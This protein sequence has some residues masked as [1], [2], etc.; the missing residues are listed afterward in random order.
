MHRPSPADIGTGALRCDR[1]NALDGAHE[2]AEPAVDVV[3]DVGMAVRSIDEVMVW[4][5]LPPSASRIVRVWPT[6]PQ[7]SGSSVT[8]RIAGKAA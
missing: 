1:P 2:G 8:S 7:S 4:R 6:V 3:E 5:R